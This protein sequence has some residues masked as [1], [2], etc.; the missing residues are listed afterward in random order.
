MPWSVGDRDRCS[1]PWRPLGNGQVPRGD[2]GGDVRPGLGS[3]TPIPPDLSTQGGAMG[4]RISQRA[5]AAAFGLLTAGATALI[6]M[7]GHTPAQAAVWTDQSDYPPGS[8]VTIHGDNSDGAGYQANETVH[9]DVNGPGSIGPSC[10][11]TADDSGAWSCQITLGTG[12]AAIGGYT[13]T[14]T[15]QTSGISQSGTFTD[16]GCKDAKSQGTVLP[17][18]DVT[19]S[20][21]TSGSTATYSITTPADT[22]SGGI[23]GLIEY[24][25]FP[26]S[27]PFP[28][29]AT[30]SYDSWKANLDTTNGY[31]DFERPHGDPTNLP[32]DGT[33]Q[34]VGTADWSGAVPTAQQ[35]MLH[36]NDPDEC[37]ALYGAGTLTCFVLPGSGPSNQDLQVT[38]TA[39]PSFTRTYK[40]NISKSVDSA[41]QNIPAG[42]SATFN[43]TVAVTHDG[44]TDSGWQVTG[45]ITV[46]N[47]NTTG[48]AGV[49]VTDSSDQGGNCAV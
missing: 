11:A 1:V 10:D 19:A 25:I 36:I 43:Y 45:K 2:G 41:Q 34:T 6:L 13:Y 30:A 33:T 12:A 7:A 3:P 15:G 38:K 46:K 17:S 39:T 32:F 42:S 26:G 9:V 23:P 44:G 22:G 24:C 21:T 37:A 47:P 49:N 27:S 8:V 14:A 20:F 31:F 5:V 29:T 16:S 35:I 18:P 48:F 40:W 28:N 4:S